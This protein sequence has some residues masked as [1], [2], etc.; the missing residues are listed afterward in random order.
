MFISYN[1]SLYYVLYDF[2][3]LYWSPFKIINKG[4]LR[5]KKNIRRPELRHQVGGK[6]NHGWNAERQDSQIDLFDHY[7]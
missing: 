5:K 7:T 6:L 1:Q 2:Q 4:L 3:T